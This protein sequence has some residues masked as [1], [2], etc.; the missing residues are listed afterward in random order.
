MAQ[1]SGLRHASW[2]HLYSTSFEESIHCTLGYAERPRYLFTGLSRKVA[3]TRF[4]LLLF[5]EFVGLF[6]FGLYIRV[7]PSVMAFIEPSQEFECSSLL[8]AVGFGE[9]CWIVELVDCSFGI[10]QSAGLLASSDC[11]AVFLSCFR[12]SKMFPNS[13]ANSLPSLFGKPHTSIG[14]RSGSDV[15]QRY[16]RLSVEVNSLLFQGVARFGV[17]FPLVNG[18]DKG[19]LSVLVPSGLKMMITVRVPTQLAL[20]LKESVFDIETLADIDAP[21]CLAGNRVYASCH[22]LI[23]TFSTKLSRSVLD[24]AFGEFV[25]QVE[26]KATWSFK[27]SVRVGRFFPSTK[28]CSECGK[29]NVNVTLSD[30]VWLCSSCG[31]QHDRDLNAA[32]N[33]L[34]EGMRVLA[35]GQTE[36]QNARGEPVSLPT[37]STAR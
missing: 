13:V 31:T 21:V 18:E 23:I 26:Y 4:L 25:R 36:S 24:A 9:G 33:I 27:H 14:S 17:R 20:V 30:R 22:V 16:S 37:G 15:E 1:L 32:R 3:G 12:R 10:S 6:R 35:A 2:A 7:R 11:H 8:Q 5:C 19:F 34:A 29:V 28:L